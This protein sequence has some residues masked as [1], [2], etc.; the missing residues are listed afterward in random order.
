MI[1]EIRTDRLLLRPFRA[2]DRPAWAEIHADP[3]VMETLGPVMDRA[4]SDEL[5]DRLVARGEEL[6]YG[7]WCVDLDGECI[8]GAAVTTPSWTAPFMDPRRPTIE[9]GWRIASPRWGRGY[10]PEAARAAVAFGFGDLAAP[11][12]VAFTAETNTKSRRV[13]DKL[14]MVHD[15]TGDFD[16]PNLDPGN[17]LRRHVLYR[18][19]RPG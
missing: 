15:P 10:A 16:H 18:L 4:Q 14:A 9:I 13:M 6:G 8:G 17:P 7:W 5:L 3:L 11:E 12:L 2:A 1:P 19:P